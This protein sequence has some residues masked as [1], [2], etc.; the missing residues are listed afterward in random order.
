[1]LQ[2]E[3]SLPKLLIDK[4]NKLRRNISIATSL[5]IIVAVITTFSEV[6]ASN[7]YPFEI[8]IY[9]YLS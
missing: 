9:N 7:D 1:M 2:L 6:Q 4:I 5:D 3:D 8:S